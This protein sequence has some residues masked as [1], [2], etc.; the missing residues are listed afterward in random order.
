MAASEALT[1]RKEERICSRKLMDQL[2]NG[3]TARSMSSFPL[4]VVF[5]STERLPD[6]PPV[7]ILI[8]VPKRHFHHAVDRNRVKRQLREAFR[9]NK[10]MLSLPEK[11]HADIAFVWLDDKHYDT[12]QVEKRVRKLLVRINESSVQEEARAMLSEET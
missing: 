3:D 5:L 6:Q 10:Q 4:R 2:F 8:S 12:R 1:L 11:T 7:S 9:L